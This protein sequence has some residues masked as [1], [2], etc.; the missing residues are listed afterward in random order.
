MEHKAAENNYKYIGA[1]GTLL[2][3]KEESCGFFYMSSV[4]KHILPCLNKMEDSKFQ[5]KPLIISAGKTNRPESIFK[6]TSMFSG[7]QYCKLDVLVFFF[8]TSGN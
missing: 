4:I 6:F 2:L 3:I 8:G 5:R 1:Q 7:R